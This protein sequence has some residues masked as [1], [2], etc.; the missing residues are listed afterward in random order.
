YKSGR[1]ARCCS[2]SLKVA[3]MICSFPLRQMLYRSIA[4]NRQTV[5]ACL[6]LGEIEHAVIS[7]PALIR[8]WA[9]ASHKPEDF[10]EFLRWRISR[11]SEGIRRDFDCLCKWLMVRYHA[12]LKAKRNNNVA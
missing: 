4:S 7:S 9:D 2:I 8:T 6:R 3:R 12:C 5:S 11:K 10:V 1:D